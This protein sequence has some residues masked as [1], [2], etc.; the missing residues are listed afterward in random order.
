M[1][2]GKKYNFNKFNKNN[3]KAKIIQISYAMINYNN[4]MY[5]NQENQIVKVYLLR[6]PQVT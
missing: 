6:R 3:T 2:I 5:E 1:F 4:F